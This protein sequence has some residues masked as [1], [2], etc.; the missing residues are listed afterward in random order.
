MPLLAGRSPSPLCGGGWP[1][2]QR[3][4]GE[5]DPGSGKVA[6]FI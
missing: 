5:G 2:R 1:S 4:S 6:A 3:G